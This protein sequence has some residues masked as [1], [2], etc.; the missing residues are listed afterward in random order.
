MTTNIHKTAQLGDLVAA[1][2]DQAAHYSTDP[3]EV[4]RLATQAVMQVVRRM[5]RTLAPPSRSRMSSL[6]T[7]FSPL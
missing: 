5:R 7:V 6:T 2:F 4:S 1:A 3:S